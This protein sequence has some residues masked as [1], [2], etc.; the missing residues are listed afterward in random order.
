MGQ[1]YKPINLDSM[2]H[3]YP[4]DYDNG[5]KLMEHSW[6]ENDFV[7]VVENLLAPEGKWHRCRLVWAGDYADPETDT[8]E[9]LFTLSTKKPSPIPKKSK[10]RYIVNHT[11]RLYIDKKALKE[12]EKGW[13]IHPLPLLTSEGNGRGGGDYRGTN[14]NIGTWA[15]DSISMELEPPKDYKEMAIIFTEKN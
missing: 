2:T 15:R 7:E 5:L 11:K 8:E 10:Y 9:N 4:H 13:T 6:I 14:K 1:Y 12:E 3:V